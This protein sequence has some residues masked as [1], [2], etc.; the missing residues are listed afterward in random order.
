TVG[1][2][3]CHDHKFDPL[4][5]NE[6]YRLFAF[7][8]NVP[9]RGKAIKYGNS[10]PWVVSPTADQQHRLAL[11]DA[12][13]DAAE[14]RFHAL[15]STL[16]EALSAWKPG[17]DT[18]ESADWTPDGGL[19]AHY[20]LDGN[21]REVSGRV[22]PGRLAVEDGG[23]AEGRSGQALVCDGQQFVDAGNVGD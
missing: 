11:L 4:A 8:N 2:A 17:R 18:A 3:R 21:P 14:R 15:E 12:R 20:P 22:E 10:P 19:E 6:F 7:F 13:R 9:E 16:A 1:C 5:Q 23:F